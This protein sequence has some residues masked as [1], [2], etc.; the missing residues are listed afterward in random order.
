[1]PSLTEKLNQH[2]FESNDDYD[3]QVCCLLDTPTNG[4]RTLNIE[5]DGERRKTAFAQ[6]LARA[7]EFSH[8]LYHDFTDTHPPLPDVILPPSR[9]EL[10]REE[11]PIEPFDR[12]VTEAC[13]QSEGDP[14]ALILDQLQAADF[15]EHM[16]LYRL[17]KD[18]LWEVRGGSYFANPNR[19]L[20]ILISE[21]PLYHALRQESFRLWIGRQ[22]ER[23]LVY[24]PVD[25]GLGP[26]AQ[27]VFDALTQLFEALQ[28][29]PTRRE[30]TRLLDD[31]RRHVR[32]VEHLR[33]SLYGRLEAI[34]REALG[35]PRL[36]GLQD[37][38]LEATQ[39]WLIAE[40]I[41]LSDDRPDPNQEQR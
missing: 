20:I 22:S 17:I 30:F 1:M 27:P 19:L 38:I 24:H 28:V 21:Q 16:R 9:D 13:A 40:H 14:T 12:I 3:F 34:E 35:D 5:G 32:T 8:I 36:R 31:I 37:Q 4:I 23:Q 33:L 18:G 41:E 25:F 2:G 29:A 10:G 15:R 11:P 26:E 39:H 6:A 7:L